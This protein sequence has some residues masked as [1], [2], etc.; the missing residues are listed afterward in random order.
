MKPSYM[1]DLTRSIRKVIAPLSKVEERRIIKSVTTHMSKNYGGKAAA[2]FRVLE[3][4]L[5]IDKPP[6]RESIPQRLIRVLVADY[7]NKQNLEFVLDAQGKIIRLEEYRGLQPAFHKEEIREA[8]TIAKRDSRL[9][10]VTKRRR[11]FISDFAPE[12]I[13]E[14]NS[15]RIV[16]LN[17][18]LKAKDNV[19]Q[20]L[21][22]VLV[23][24]S[25]QKVV[26]LESTEAAIQET[27]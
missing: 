15:F 14:N 4:Q 16:G 18:V 11:V 10:H 27:T 2:R 7:R 22:R 9:A 6:R 12:T 21:A 20:Q 26:S 19:F 17:Y 3:M 1:S 23:D 5:S 24:L 8:Q 13:Q 25:E